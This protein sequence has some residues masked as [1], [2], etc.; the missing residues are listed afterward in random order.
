MAAR[1]LAFAA[2]TVVLAQQHDHFNILVANCLLHHPLTMS[3]SVEIRFCV[4][5]AIG[6]HCASMANSLP[7]TVTCV[8][9]RDK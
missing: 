8:I 4:P 3:I 9:A 7:G 6:E 5:E 2:K 1:V